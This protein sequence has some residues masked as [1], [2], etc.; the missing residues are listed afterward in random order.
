MN[1]M[2][3]AFFTLLLLSVLGK[4]VVAEDFLTDEAL[5][6]LGVESEIFLEDLPPEN[7]ETIL[8]EIGMDLS[9]WEPGA[10][11]KLGSFAYLTMQTFDVKGGLLYSLFPGPHY[12][13]RELQSVGLIP[14]HWKANQTMAADE[15]RAILGNLRA[16]IGEGGIE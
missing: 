4:P 16:L 13:L 1:K 6:L 12:A 2:P 11:V 8:L 7:P 15:A 10:A 9:G 3:T 5:L 14:D